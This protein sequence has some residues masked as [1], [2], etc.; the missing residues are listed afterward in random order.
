[1]NYRLILSFVFFLAMSGLTTAQVVCTPG[2]VCNP[3]FFE[4]SAVEGSGPTEVI[5][6]AR[7]IST[8]ER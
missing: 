8:P 6:R 4:M 3:G 5:I 2:A 7:A 1:M